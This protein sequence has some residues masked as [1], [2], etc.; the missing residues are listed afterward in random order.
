M[1]RKAKL[2]LQ[3]LP[4]I[5]LEIYRPDVSFNL[6]QAPTIATGDYEELIN[7]PQI[8]GVT[9]LD[10]KTGSDLGLVNAET[11]KGLSTNDYTNEDKAKVTSVSTGANK[12]E[13]SYSGTSESL[14]KYIKIDG[15][16]YKLSGADGG[17]YSAK[18]NS[19]EV[20]NANHT[21]KVKVSQNQGNGLTLRNDGLFA[22]SSTAE[23]QAW[24][25]LSQQKALESQSSATASLGYSQTAAEQAT[26]AG[27]SAASAGA[28]WTN[29]KRYIVPCDD[30]ADYQAKIRS[31]EI[32][33]NTI[34]LFP[35]LALEEDE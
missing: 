4:D 19:M 30:W 13:V 20:D 15:T 35:E 6:S 33:D 11:G 7:K 12:T 16:E 18:D 34:A 26:Q 8:N 1:P 2:T 21:L 27:N 22:V 32:T 14:V 29:I 31:G 17:S 25:E 28:S 24:A 3:E 5:D 9:L 23:A 10:N